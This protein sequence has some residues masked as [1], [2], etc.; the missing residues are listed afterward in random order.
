MSSDDHFE[1]EGI[2]YSVIRDRVTVTLDTNGCQILCTLS[3]KIRQ[4]GIKILPM[5]RV[6]LR[7]SP[8]DTTRGVISYRLKA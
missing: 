7:I 3:G 5:D 1:L 2:V 8:Y 6:R 4:S